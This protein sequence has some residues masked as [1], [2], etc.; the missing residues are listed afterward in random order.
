MRYPARAVGRETP[1]IGVSFQLGQQVPKHRQ[2]RAGSTIT[3]VD[4]HSQL[5]E[6]LVAGQGHAGDVGTLAD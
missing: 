1:G 4:G 5:V 6:E 3:G 2:D